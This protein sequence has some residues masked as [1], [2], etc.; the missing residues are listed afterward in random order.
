M[1]IGITLAGSDNAVYGALTP[2]K[3]CNRIEI[4]QLAIDELY[5]TKTK[6]Y[7]FN[8]N[9]PNYWDYHIILHCYYTDGNTEAGNAMYKEATLVKLKKRM[10]GEFDWKT[11]YE[12]PV[13]KGM[14]LIES[15][16]IAYDDYLEPNK[17]QVEYAYVAVIKNMETEPMTA[18]ATAKFFNYWLVG[19][20]DNGV[21]KVYPAMFNIDNVVNLNRQSNVI[22]S[23]GR[24][25]PYVVNNGVAKYYSGTFTAT[26][27]PH[28]SRMEPV[29]NEAYKYRDAVDDFMA[30]GL[31]KILKTLDGDIYLISITGG[32]NRTNHTHYQNIS[33]T[34]EWVE[35]GDP[36]S[37]GDLYDYGF[38]NTDRD[39]SD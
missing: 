7:N 1:F 13:K 6:L 20:F 22:V 37:I 38:I 14:N 9:I 26:F 29:P 4:Y 16:N 39:R 12:Q 27:M 17:A 33:Q 36:F 25:Y 23:P 21:Q 32:L 34:F 5:A 2:A 11:I 15:L 8:W 3:T 30:D 31:P 28:D 19:Q 10:K 24:K 35:I 18:S